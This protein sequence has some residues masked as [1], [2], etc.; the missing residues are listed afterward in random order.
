MKRIKISILIGTD[1]RTR[2]FFRQ[3]INRILEREKEALLDFSNVKFVSRSVA[4]EIYNILL[5]YPRVRV[6]RLEGDVAM[7]Y[8]IVRHSRL[9]KRKFEP[10]NIPIV[11]LKTMDDLMRFFSTHNPGR[12]QVGAANG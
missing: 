12:P 1:I 7:M 8:S 3:D 4:D 10:A 9:T 2:N 5:D 11:T 6:C